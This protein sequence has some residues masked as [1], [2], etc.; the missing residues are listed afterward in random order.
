MIFGIGTDILEIE[1]INK[2]LNKQNEKFIDRIYGSNE[3]NI[4]RNNQKN[5][6]H[7]LSK[8]FAAKEATWKAF[9]P[10]RG[11]GLIF[12]EIETLND[13]NGKPYLFFSGKTER[14]IKEKEN[15][16][17]GKLKF[18]ISLSDE[19]QYVIAFVVI[20]LAPFG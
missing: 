8:R 6:N 10:K 11:D 16:L 5:L 3:I 12:K 1:R 19:R 14:Y 4:I 15:E 13:R 9:N 2:I 20:S 18:D 17:N 7:F